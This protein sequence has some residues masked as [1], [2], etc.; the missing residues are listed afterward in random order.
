MKA[1]SFIGILVILINFCIRCVQPEFSENYMVD[2]N[3][4]RMGQFLCPDPHINHI[5]PK[6]QQLKGCTKEGRTKGMFVDL[7]HFLFRV[8]IL[9][10]LL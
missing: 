3:K 7:S 5:D 10:F 8:F 6:T 4:L 9:F 1:Y 2:C